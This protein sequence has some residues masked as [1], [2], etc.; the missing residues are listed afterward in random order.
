[1]TLIPADRSGLIARDDALRAGFT[2]QDLDHAVSQNHL[3]Q[4]GPGIFALAYGY[5]LWSRN[6]DR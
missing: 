1:M 4:L 2:D 6:A 3:V 5:L